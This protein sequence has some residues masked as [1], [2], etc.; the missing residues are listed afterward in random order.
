MKRVLKG[1]IKT[2]P[3]VK[4]SNIRFV[5]LSVKDDLAD[6]MENMYIVCRSQNPVY[7]KPQYALAI[8]NFYHTDY[9]DKPEK[10]SLDS[11]SDEEV[12]ELYGSTD[13]LV[14]LHPKTE[15]THKFF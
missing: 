10:G 12:E 9:E 5:S 11:D 2:Q 8:Y 1:L 7:I 13:P 15:I 14:L 6:F 3:E 4:E